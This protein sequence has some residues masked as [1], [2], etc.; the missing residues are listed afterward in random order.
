[1]S[2]DNG[3]ISVRQAMMLFIVMFCAPAI[4]YIP[5]FSTEQAKQAAWLAPLIACVLEFVYMM[6]WYKF[7]EKY[8][9]KSFVDIIKAILGKIIGNIVVI[10]YFLW[11]TFLLSYNLKMYAERIVSTVMPDV[12]I[13]VILLVMLITVVYVVKNGIIT[14]TKMNELFFLSLGVIFILYNI[15]IL[16]S[17]EIKNLFPITYK[18]AFPIFKANFAILT[19]F[20]YN[21]V[22]FMFNDKIDH[23]GEFKKL[24]IKTLVI[25]TII[26]ILVIAVPLCVF[27]WSIVVK[28]PVPYLSTMMEISLF[29]IIERIEAGIIIFWIISDFIISAIFIYSAIHIIK[30]SFNLSNVKPLLS[31]YVIGIFFLSLILANSTLELQTLSEIIITPL[32][33][34]M[35]YIIPILIFGVGKLRKKV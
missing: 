11:I 33:I 12:N 22:I 3:K 17:I 26:S 18:D 15:L 34:I 25:I 20:A 29:N 2:N 4:R 23:K 21:I 16:P 1:M 35:G 19:I 10:I 6:V 24:S 14:M 8:R 31:I 30:I 27:G 32:N 9:D 28:M 7:L 13:I 5:V